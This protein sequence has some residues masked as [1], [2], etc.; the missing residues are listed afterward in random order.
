MIG[1]LKQK[2]RNKPNN[3]A[4][5]QLTSLLD[6]MTILLF[7][8]L[9]HYSAT[10]DINMAKNLQLPLSISMRNPVNA[11]NIAISTSEISVDGNAII[12]L[13]DSPVPGYKMI[14]QS[15][16]QKDRDLIQPLLTELKKKRAYAENTAALDDRL[17]FQGD[18]IVQADK[19][20][21]YE[22]LRKILYTAGQADYVQLN[23]A[24]RYGE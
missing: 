9:K 19:S 18:C 16:F 20:I 14:P 1:R 24:V 2:R 6:I 10:A 12:E 11:L 17:K 22:L 15:A 8:L 7:F 5:I 4:M 21:P 23:F 13:V 3:V